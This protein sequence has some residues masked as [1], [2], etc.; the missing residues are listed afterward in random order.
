[1]TPDLVMGLA[2]RIDEAFL[3]I[4]AAILLIEIAEAL[5]K[6]DHVGR[7]IWE[8]VVSASTQI[9]YLLVETLILT[10]GYGVYYIL[11]ETVAAWSIPITWWSVMLVLLLADITYYW[12]HRI[13]HQ[14]RLLWTQHAVHHSSRDYNIVT[15]VRFGPLE[16]VWSLAAHL[17]LIVLGF[18]PELV[19]FGVIV[20]LAYQTWLH[21]ELIGKLGPLERVLNTPSHHRVHHGADDKYLDRNYGG[22]T[23]IWDR[24]FGTFQ[25]EEEPPRYGLKR[26]FNSRNPVVVWFSEWPA[27]IRDMAGARSWGEAWAYMV[28]RPGWRPNGAEHPSEGSPNRSD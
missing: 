11:S 28:K 15:G 7:T 3:L 16:G 8:M 22:I 9:P 17:P 21:T 23:I 20:V 12:E 6:R 25:V 13:A 19:F 14:V 5:F 18:A 26:D 4:G 24:L 27:L 2:T 10:A 1:M